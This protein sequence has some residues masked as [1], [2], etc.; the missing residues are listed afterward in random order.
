MSLLKMISSPYSVLRNLRVC[1]HYHSRP[2][3]PRSFWTAPRIET[4]GRSQF[5]SM[6]STRSVFFSPFRFVIFDNESVNRKLP[7]LE[8]VRGLNSWRRPE[9]SRLIWGRE[10]VVILAYMK[11]LDP[12]FSSLPS[13]FDGL[14]CRFGRTSMVF[15]RFRLA[16]ILWVN[17]EGKGRLV[18][19]FLF[20]LAKIP[21]CVFVNIENRD[22]AACT[23]NQLRNSGIKGWVD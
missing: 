6:R 8:A 4:S 10:C 16:K 18:S 3:R 7:V 1:C 12:P 22:C 19:E 2:Q 21:S 5:L 11:F 13:R 15:S 9:G 20:W 14:K 23:G 17:N